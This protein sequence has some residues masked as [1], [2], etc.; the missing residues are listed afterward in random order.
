MLVFSRGLS[1]IIIVGDSFE[2]NIKRKKPIAKIYC[3]TQKYNMIITYNRY[4]VPRVCLK[5]LVNN[6]S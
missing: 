5:K 4:Y 2:N 6:K 3:K 1:A